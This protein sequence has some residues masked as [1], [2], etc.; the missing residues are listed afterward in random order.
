MI[1]VMLYTYKNDNNDNNWSYYL[2][3]FIKHKASTKNLSIQVGI[4]IN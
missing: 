4:N 1:I 3:L 2:T